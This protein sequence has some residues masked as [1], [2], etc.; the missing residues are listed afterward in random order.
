ME[1]F[2]KTGIGI[3][4]LINL[5]ENFSGKFIKMLKLFSIYFNMLGMSP[6]ELVGW[7]RVDNRLA[8][9]WTFF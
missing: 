6:Y 7:R 5:S 8:P 1:T 9:Y 4:H 3:R 2:K